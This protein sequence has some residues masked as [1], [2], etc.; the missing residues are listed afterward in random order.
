MSTRQVSAAPFKAKCL[1]INQETGSD[2]RSVTVTRRGRPV[3]VLSPPVEREALP[4]LGMMRGTVLAYE[5]P[6]APLGLRRAALIL[7]DTLEACLLRS[8]ART[9]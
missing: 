7:L 2:G 4:F 1:R 8:E 5:D 3:A 9:T 6:L